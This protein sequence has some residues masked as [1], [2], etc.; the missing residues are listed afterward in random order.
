MKVIR[1]QR[2]LQ[3]WVIGLLAPAWETELARYYDGFLNAMKKYSSAERSCLAFSEVCDSRQELCYYWSDCIATTFI[4]WGRSQQGHELPRAHSGLPLAL[5]Y[6]WLFWSTP[7]SALSEEGWYMLFYC[8]LFIGGG[9]DVEGAE[10]WGMDE[11][12]GLEAGDSIFI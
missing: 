4:A 10:L 1:K 7:S 9:T 8:C 12:E 6:R 11:S 2:W 3:L 5:P